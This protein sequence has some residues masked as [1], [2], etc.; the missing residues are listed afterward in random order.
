MDYRNFKAP[1]S[2]ASGACRKQRRAVALAAAKHEPTRLRGNTIVDDDV[3]VV[4]DDADGE[5]G[6]DDADAENAA[7]KHGRWWSCHAMLCYMMSWY[8]L[9]CAN[10][11]CSEIE[12]V[13]FYAIISV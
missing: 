3:D 8:V 2:R 10:L 9:L 11:A 7:R 4:D 12:S 5:D 13:M 1:C 6:G